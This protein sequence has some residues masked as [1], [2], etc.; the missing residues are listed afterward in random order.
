MTAIGSFEAKTHLSSL[1]ARVEQGEEFVITRHGVAVARLMPVAPP[2][3][4]SALDAVRQLKEFRKGR[5]M[6]RR[7]IRRMID[8]GR[9]Y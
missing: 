8:E 5:R 6:S 7:Q 4:C 3:G 9:K 2:Q 1:L